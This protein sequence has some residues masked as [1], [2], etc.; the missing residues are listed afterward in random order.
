MPIDKR[1]RKRLHELLAIGVMVLT[2]GGGSFLIH[3]GAGEGE[4]DFLEIGW[5]NI[6]DLSDQSRTDEEIAQIA[7]V[8]EDLE[9]IAVGELNDPVALARVAQSLGME[10]EWAT[11]SDKIGRKA[12]TREYYGFLW[13][14]DVVDMLDSVRVDPDPDD[15]FDR[16]PAWATFRTSDGSM[17]FTV[18]AVHITWGTRVE[19]RKA[20]IRALA[21][22]WERTQEATATDDDLIL[23]GDFNRKIGDD[24]FIP[25]LS[26]PGIV[27]ANEDTGP[28]N[29]S[30]RTTYDQIFIS[31]DGTHEWTGEYATIRFDELF[32]ENNDAMA[33]QAVS[34]HRPVWIRLMIPALDDD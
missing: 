12:S 34:D 27:R 17:D 30:S 14:S 9:V 4:P 33:R 20:E 6:R 29:I 24:S 3:Q 31:L 5:W 2:I 21:Q 25:L 1:V 19:P 32:F 23:V 11:T 26:L 13:N 7:M 22:V 18:I 28:T 15:A 10:W 16:E 8:V